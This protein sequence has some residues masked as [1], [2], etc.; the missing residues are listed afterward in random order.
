MEQRGGADCDRGISRDVLAVLDRV[1]A[2]RIGHAIVNH[3]DDIEGGRHRLETQLTAQVER[4]V[5]EVSTVIGAKA[6]VLA[7]LHAFFFQ[8]VCTHFAERF[9]RGERFR[10]DYEF[11]ECAGLG[12]KRALEGGGEIG[13]GLDTLGVEA[14]GPAEGHE[15]GIPGHRGA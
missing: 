7:A 13:R 4:D 9:E 1:D 10:R 8:G 5:R 2:G 15:I 6:D 14:I 3:R 12:G 11:E